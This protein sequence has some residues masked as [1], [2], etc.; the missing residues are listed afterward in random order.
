MLKYVVI[1]VDKLEPDM[2]SFE[3]DTLKVHYVSKGQQMVGLRFRHM[4]PTMI[5]DMI[6]DR[7]Y[8]TSYGE[9]KFDDWFD[10]CVKPNAKKAT[11]IRHA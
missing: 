7:T 10:H 5:I 8:V 3:T 4:R 2:R 6:E 11:Y 9:D 1:L